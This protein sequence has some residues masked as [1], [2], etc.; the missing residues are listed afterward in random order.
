MGAFEEFCIVLEGGIELNRALLISN[1]ASGHNRKHG[2]RGVEN[3]AA[4]VGLRHHCF[5]DISTLTDVLKHCAQREDQLVIVNA[6]DGTVCQV[7]QN[8]RER[9]LFVHE[10]TLALLRGGTT[11][12]IHN[13]VGSPGRP[14]AALRTLLR[15]LDRR[16]YRQEKRHILHVRQ[17]S[18]RTS[19]YGF[20]L[21]THAAVKAILRTRQ[22]LH[23]RIST[24]RL[25][26]LLSVI[27]M[28]W[29]LLQRRVDSD[30]LLSPAP[31]EFSRNGGP[32]QQE[33][34][35]LL[36]VMTVKTAILGIRPL[37]RSQR[38]GLAILNWPGYRLFPWL[39]RFARGNLQEFDSISLRGEFD[40]I[41]DGEVYEHRK[42]DGTLTIDVASPVRFLVKGSKW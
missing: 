16:D 11:N 24:G 2:I 6:G 36:L 21:G 19:R 31:L 22:R 10:P 7:L 3:V 34:Q 23:T 18:L 9:K 27:A 32:W 40:W 26:E 13:D 41:L 37:M 38:A 17:S 39:S 1:T 5:D 8:I 30:P 25:S 42:N 29:H 4:E 20:F 35:I 12:M 14:E 28:I 33:L 15:C